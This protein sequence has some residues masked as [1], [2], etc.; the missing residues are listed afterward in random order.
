MSD[1]V[2]KTVRAMDAGE[3]TAPISGLYDRAAG[4]ARQQVAWLNDGIRDRPLTATVVA[5]GVGYLL[6]WLRG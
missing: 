3:A 6:G 5:L 1:H 4:Q 2:G